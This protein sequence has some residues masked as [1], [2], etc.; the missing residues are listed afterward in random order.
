MKLEA[1]THERMVLNG[2]VSAVLAVLIPPYGLVQHLE[3]LSAF[4]L[5]DRD[6]K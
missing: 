1:S 3:Q 5:D 2:A 6:T 4:V